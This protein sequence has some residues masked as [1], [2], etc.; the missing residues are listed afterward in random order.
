MLALANRDT[1][2]H[3]IEFFRGKVNDNGIAGLLGNLYAESGV[4]TN[5]LQNSCNTKYGMTDEEFTKAVD[6]GTF[7]FCDPNE[8]FGYGLAQWTSFGRRI[9][10]YNHCKS[11]NASIADETSQFEWLYLELQNSYKKVLAELVSASNTIASCA[12]IVVCKYEVPK[13]VLDGGIAKQNTIDKRISYALEF[14]NE[15]LNKGQKEEEQ[16]MSIDIKTCILTQNGC[17]KENRH[18]IPKRIVVHSTGA[19]NKTLKRYVQPDDGILGTNKYNNH[20]NKAGVNKCVN[21]FIGEDANG[22]VRIY[23]TLPWDMRPWGCGSGSKGSY[24][25]DAIQFEMCEDNLT[26]EKYFNKV[27]DAATSL[28]AFLCTQYKIPVTEVVS[29]HEAY[30]RGYANGHA[31]CDHWLKKFGKTM[32]WFRG[33]V[34][35]KMTGVE[36]VK[37]EEVKPVTTD[38]SYKVR[39]TTGNLNI[40]S[41]PGITNKVVGSIKDKGVYTIVDESG[42]W[43]KLKSG[44]GWIS[45]LYTKKV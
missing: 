1:V 36:S 13:S 21:G 30:I 29:H 45:L 22:T 34:Q 27:M 16:E 28:C 35:E 7:N 8:K 4:R 23:Q 33:R 17:Y 2:L 19:N 41:G 25:N 18:I 38:A 5:N 24:N 26:D 42:T 10:L 11:K 32:D 20:W 14:Y 43:G 44:A 3:F 39:V 15:F 12:E 40:R 31:D 37:Q 9:G 6:N